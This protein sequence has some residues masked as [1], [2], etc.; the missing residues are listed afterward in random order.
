MGTPIVFNLLHLFTV[1]GS[2]FTFK[3]GTIY[4]D[5]ETMLVFCYSATSDGK[6]KTGVFQKRNLAG[7]STEPVPENVPATKQAR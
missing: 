3:N 4:I 5:N 2:T 6:L 7:Y 1:H